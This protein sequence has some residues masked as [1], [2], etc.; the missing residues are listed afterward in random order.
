[1]AGVL[2]GLAAGP[3]PAQRIENRFPRPLTT[4]IHR[5]RPTTRA[6]S[7]DRTGSKIIGALVG[8]GIGLVGGAYVGSAIDRATDTGGCEDCGL[9]GAIIGAAIGEGLLLGTGVHL[10][11]PV[12]RKT[13]RRLLFSPLI[14]G[15]ALLAAIAT[16]QAAVMLIALPI[17]IAVVW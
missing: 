8:G 10:A 13:V 7:V 11:D 4:P 1:M 16:N 3:L 6:D 9:V 17:Q 12:P 5:Y 2:V 14:A 15:G